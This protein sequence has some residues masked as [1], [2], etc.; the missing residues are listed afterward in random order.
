MVISVA[1]NQSLADAERMIDNVP[2]QA[3]LVDARGQI[4]AVNAYWRQF[5]EA[6]GYAD[7]SLGL[8]RNYLE[9]CR[10]AD[11]ATT[12]E[13]HV[14]AEELEQVLTGKR[15]EFSLVYP[16][17]SPTERR[18]FR[19]LAAG[20]RDAAGAVILHFNIT[21]EMLA[22]ERQAASRIR[23]ERKLSR[24]EQVMQKSSRQ[25]LRALEDMSPA[26]QPD[27]SEIDDEIRIAYRAI[28]DISSAPT[29]DRG[30]RV[31]REMSQAVARKLADRDA[32]ASHV[33][34]LH[35]EALEDATR[36]ASSKRAAS[37]IQ[38]SRMAFIGVLGYLANI[39]RETPRR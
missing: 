20:T 12:A 25:E 19:L 32:D 28:I 7:Q 17:H 38:E 27:R 21:P 37:I 18:W 9:T 11:S 39:Y 14:V 26:P 13:A 3:A 35:A 8:G 15:D 31:L 4:V 6:N 10:T 24:Y 5:A 36:N 33:A 2:V 1:R 30:S 16:C 29:G 22:E 34:R 23:A